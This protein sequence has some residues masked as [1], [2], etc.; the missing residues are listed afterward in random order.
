MLLLRTRMA[1]TELSGATA[2]RLGLTGTPKPASAS[3]GDLVGDN[4]GVLAHADEER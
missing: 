1:L 3:C 4:G 2:G